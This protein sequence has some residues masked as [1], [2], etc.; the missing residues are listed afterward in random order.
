MDE[1]L[2]GLNEVVLKFIT[3]ASMYDISELSSIDRVYSTIFSYKIPSFSEKIKNRF[4]FSKS[5]EL[6]YHFF[7]FLDTTYGE[8]YLNKVNGDSIIYSYDPKGV[9]NATSY[10]VDNQK[11]IYLPYRQDIFDSFT[12]VHEVLHDMNLDIN[13]IN[14]VRNL[15]TE[16]IS[17][18]GEFLF[19]D[20]INENYDIR[21]SIN[22]KNNFNCC[23]LKAVDVS[24]YVDLVKEFLDNGY[25]N[26]FIFEN[27]I[28]KYNSYYH[29][30][31]IKLVDKFISKG[32]LPI[33]YE[34]RYLIGILLSCYSKDLYDNG[35]F[36]IDM[37]KYIN[38]NI[39][40]MDYEDLYELLSLDFDDS[41]T[42]LLS[43]DSYDKLGRSYEKIMGR[44]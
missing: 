22:N 39:N 3:D 35:R 34:Y 44:M 33:F 6:A 2:S 30:H 1:F 13:N 19:Q 9:D 17:I 31:L 28:V 26:K 38:E 42:L 43:S 4:G 7:D 40:S 14:N 37:F 27:I 21:C 16:Y 12:L 23:F 5:L 20:Y 10:Y 41:Y 29:D 11:M 24:F 18:L 32:N 15:Y 25:I 8:Y 36:D